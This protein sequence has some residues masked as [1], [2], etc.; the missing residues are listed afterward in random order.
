MKPLKLAPIT[1]DSTLKKGGA[2]TVTQT[3]QVTSAAW[4]SPPAIHPTHSCMGLPFRRSTAKDTGG[5]KCES[6]A[7]TVQTFN[8][9]MLL[10]EFLN[11]LDL[12]LLRTVGPH[13][14]ACTRKQRAD[15]VV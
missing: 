5:M 2:I 9:L 12:A 15:L 3:M 7:K 13:S 14:R 8:L 11:A 4:G 6:D 1:S 10:L